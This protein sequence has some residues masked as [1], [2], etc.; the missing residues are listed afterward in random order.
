MFFISS[1]SEQVDGKEGQR[2]HAAH[3]LG[4]TYNVVMQVPKQYVSTPKFLPILIIFVLVLISVMATLCNKTVFCQK[5]TSVRQETS[6]TETM[7]KEWNKRRRGR[8]CI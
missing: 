3:G 4:P 6:L 8:D 1:R 5:E 7:M 2:G